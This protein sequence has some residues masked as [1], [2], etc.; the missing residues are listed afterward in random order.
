[1]AALAGAGSIAL[2]AAL[3]LPAVPLMVV[4]A[5]LC[6]F[7]RLMSLIA[8]GACLPVSLI[9]RLTNFDNPPTTVALAGPVYGR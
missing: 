9:K 6:F 5:G 1:V 7:L 2:G 8:A 3:G 4:G